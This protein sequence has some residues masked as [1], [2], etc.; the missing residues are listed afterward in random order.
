MTQ[1]YMD[2]EFENTTVGQLKEQLWRAGD[3]EING[4]LGEYGVPSAGE[5]EKP[6]V[7]L[8]M[9]H[10]KEIEERLSRNDIVLIPLGSTEKHGPH[11]VGAQDT[12]QVTR[13]CEAV[14]RFT[15]RQGREVGLAQ[16]PWLYGNHPSHH[17]G[18]IGTIPVSPNVLYK[19]L[20]D[21]M[22]GLW[23]MGY[24]KMIFVNNHAQHWVITQAQD[25]F[26]YRYPMLPNY[27]V[28]YDWHSA[29]SEFFR[30]KDRGGPFEDD[31]IHGDEAETSLPLLLAPETVDMSRAVNT[32]PH[33]YLP[34]RTL[35]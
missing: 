17:I 31:F 19:Q 24:R 5:M 30:T 8:Q 6:G 29:V 34:P 28:N 35:Q 12:L 7:Y 22:F 21:V 18:M 3:K 20:V 1:P 11:S 16:P 4:I 26:C 25:E 15:A 33:G 14:R 13:I 32:Q 27:S 10:P 2:P 23:A 9:T